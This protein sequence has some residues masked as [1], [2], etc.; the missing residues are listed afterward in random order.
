MS[1]QAWYKHNAQDF[2][3]GVI[4]LG[5]DAIGAY[6]IVLDLIYAR[7]APIP[8][9]ARWLGGILGCST[10]M[11][12]ALVLRLIEAGKLVEIDGELSN[13]RADFELEN[14]AKNARNLAEWGAR[15]GRKRAEIARA[16]KENNDIGQAGLKPRLQADKIRED[17]I[18]SL[19]LSPTT[20]RGPNTGLQDIVFEVCRIAE[21]TSPP[22]DAVD[23][24]E[25][26]IQSG[27]DPAETIYPTVT[28]LAETARKRRDRVVVF[29]YFDKAIVEAH[30]Q[31]AEQAER[32]RIA[33]AS[34]AARYGTQSVADLE[35][36]RLAR[37]AKSG[38]VA[39]PTVKPPAKPPPPLAGGSAR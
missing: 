11:A 4:G 3:N 30:R 8:N 18:E 15:G 38:G 33:T 1:G 21:M 9:D 13:P 32:E 19:A 17:K 28:R 16:A 37:I 31:A 5:P 25:A 7:G 2:I 22:S 24:V 27:I 34:I 35:A 12:G 10:R 6:I 20:P 29:R 26:W 36:E 14:G 23:F 39:L